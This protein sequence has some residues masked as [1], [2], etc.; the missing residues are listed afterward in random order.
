MDKFADGNPAN[1]D[2]FGTMFES[3]WRETQLRYG[4]DLKGLVSKLDYLHGMGIRVIFI[5]GTPFLNMLWQA[6]S[7]AHLR[8]SLNPANRSQVTLLSTSPFLIRIGAP[9]LTGA[10]SSTKFMRVAC[11]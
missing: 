8:A 10:A 1:N 2:F 5:S 11:T 7:K 3:D 4:G 9:L 6:D